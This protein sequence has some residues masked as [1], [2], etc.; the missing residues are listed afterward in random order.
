MPK[1][2]VSCQNCGAKN[3]LAPAGS[4]P[5]SRI[6][7]CG[8]CKEPLPWL[9]DATSASFGP[10]LETELPVLVD[11]WAGWCGPCRMVAPTLETLSRELAGRLKVL[12]VD[13]DANPDLAS[14]YNA[15]SIPMLLVMKKGE[16]VETL[17]GVRPLAELRRAVEPYLPSPA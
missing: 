16:I 5:A 13:V 9:V 8:R 11:F 7:T 14:R 15:R 2:L 12:K 17:V 6:P 4:G 3:R 1:T 10:E